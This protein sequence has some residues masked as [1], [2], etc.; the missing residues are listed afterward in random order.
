MMKVIYEENCML[1]HYHLKNS[2]S[3]YLVFGTDCRFLVSTKFVVLRKRISV[4]VFGSTNIKMIYVDTGL[5]IGNF[6]SI[7][8]KGICGL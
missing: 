5:N 7:D 6:D 8:S 4:K 1:T 3:P 2:Q